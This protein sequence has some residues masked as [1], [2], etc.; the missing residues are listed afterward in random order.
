MLRLDAAFFERHAARQSSIARD[1]LMA[2]LAARHAAAGAPPDQLEAT[3]RIVDAAFADAAT[4]GVT[5]RTT[6]QKYALTI[7][8]QARWRAVP[9][10]AAYVRRMIGIPDQTWSH[11]A[12]I[13]AAYDN[14]V[15]RHLDPELRSHIV[16]EE[17]SG[18]LP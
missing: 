10:H 1:E 6:L 7:L 8:T 16:R 15:M 9:C 18:G 2:A 13:Q 11:E 14:V 12:G 17:R 3:G 4:L 5:E